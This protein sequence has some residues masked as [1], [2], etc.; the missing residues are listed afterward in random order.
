MHWLLEHGMVDASDAPDGAPALLARA[1]REFDLPPDAIRQAA[2]MARRIRTG[3]GAWAWDAAVIDWQGNEVTLL[4]GGDTLRLDRLV[5]RRDTGE[6]WVLDCKS[7][8]RPEDQP[9]LVAQ[10]NRYREAV[11]Y[12]NPG[13]AVRV[14]FLTGEGRVVEVG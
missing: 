2:A 6:W 12:A 9:G 4:H 13:A 11:Q 14:A 8:D 5:R 7:A 10:L 3:D 1:A